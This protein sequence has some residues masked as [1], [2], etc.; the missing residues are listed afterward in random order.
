[1]SRPDCGALFVE[2]NSHV[3]FLLDSRWA[4]SFRSARMHPE[5]ARRP[6]SPSG[7]R[8][9][10][11]NNGSAR[12]PARWTRAEPQDGRLRFDGAGGAERLAN[13]AARWRAVWR[14]APPFCRPLFRRERRGRKN[15]IRSISWRPR[16]AAPAAAYCLSLGQFCSLLAEA[17]APLRR[18]H[19]L[20]N[21]VKQQAVQWAARRLLLLPYLAGQNWK[22][23]IRRSAPCSPI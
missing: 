9:R 8:R 5:R 6:P 16:R 17:R 10:R 23:S 21:C 15:E 7:R 13:Y 4:A 3:A 14:G 18:A 12:E 22:Q 20:M 11:P 2:L 1:M 19:Y